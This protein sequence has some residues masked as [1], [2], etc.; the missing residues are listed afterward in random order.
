MYELLPTDDYNKQLLKLTKIEQA[1]VRKKLKLLAQ[2][3]HHP[4]LRTKKYEARKGRFEMSV[5]MDIR[6]IWR[7]AGN[8]IILLLE[9][10]HHDIL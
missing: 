3:P 2:N 8:K 9:I 10:G 4:S 6:I 1:L 7:Y 5:N